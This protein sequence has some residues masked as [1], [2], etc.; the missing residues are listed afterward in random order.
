MSS[1]AP[2]FKEYTGA[3]QYAV[4]V[5][6][7]LREDLEDNKYAKQIGTLNDYKLCKDEIIEDQSQ[8]VG[9]R[10][11]AHSILANSDY[12]NFINNLDIMGNDI[13]INGN[14]YAEMDENFNKEKELMKRENNKIDVFFTFYIKKYFAGTERR[15]R[16]VIL[17]TMIG[18]KNKIIIFEQKQR[19]YHPEGEVVLVVHTV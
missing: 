11:N 16:A 6:D 2:L 12:E 7:R 3:D 17:Y 19:P 1:P 18:D 8:F 5:K 15:L 10:Y 9:I 4:L 14:T 13:R